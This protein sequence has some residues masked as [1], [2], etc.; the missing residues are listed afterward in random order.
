MMSQL[1]IYELFDLGYPLI[2]IRVFVFL[3]L[4]MNK[5]HGLCEKF[6]LVVNIVLQCLWV[7]FLLNPHETSLIH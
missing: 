1:S 2:V 3:S 4:L 5:N 7:S 6:F